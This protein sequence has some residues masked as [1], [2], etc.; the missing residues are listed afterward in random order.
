V[1]AAAVAEFGLLASHSSYQ[2][3][4]SL[5]Q[6]KSALRG[7]DLE[8]EYKKEFYELVKMAE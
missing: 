5:K 4:A 6:I 7:L 3:E 2:G 1:F 8:D